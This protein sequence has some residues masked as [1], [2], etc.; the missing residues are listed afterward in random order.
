MQLGQQKLKDFLQIVIEALTQRTNMDSCRI[1][2]A[3]QTQK[4]TEVPKKKPDESRTD[5]A[6]SHL[7]WVFAAVSSGNYDEDP[8]VY[9]WSSLHASFLHTSIKKHTQ[10]LLYWGVWLLFC[11]LHKILIKNLSRSLMQVKFKVNKSKN[12][13]K[14]Y[15]IQMFDS[16]HFSRKKG[17]WLGGRIMMF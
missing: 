11:W 15:S 7:C 4:R 10:L 6:F 14:A 1:R 2:I 8:T 12:F 16:L 9:P 13:Q 17:S 5:Y 3:W